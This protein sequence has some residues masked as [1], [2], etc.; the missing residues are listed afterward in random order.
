MVGFPLLAGV[1]GVIVILFQIWLPSILPFAFCHFPGFPVSKFC[2]CLLLFSRR[3]LSMMIP[4]SRF[5]ILDAVVG[6]DDENGVR[7]L[8]MVYVEEE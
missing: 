8:A 5:S 1:T 2:C 6:I 7:R 4:D 3:F